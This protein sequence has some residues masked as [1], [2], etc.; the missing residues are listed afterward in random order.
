MLFPPRFFVNTNSLLFNGFETMQAQQHASAG[1]CR[2]AR[3]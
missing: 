2:V 1:A 3:L